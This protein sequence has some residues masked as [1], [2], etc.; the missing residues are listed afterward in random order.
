MPRPSLAVALLLFTLTP[1]CS[2]SGSD[3]CEVV[4]AKSAECQPDG[5]GEDICID[6]CRSE[7]AR[8]SYRTAVERQAEC[9][10]E[11]GWSCA[12]LAIGACDYSPED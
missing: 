4:C 1:G 7:S 12:D 8:V 5:P 2:S 6:L 10:E 9:Y 3:P 11:E